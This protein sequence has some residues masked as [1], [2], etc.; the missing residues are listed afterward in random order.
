MP[1][2]CTALTAISWMLEPFG[3]VSTKSSI[4]LPSR[5]HFDTTYNKVIPE[6][7]CDKHKK[8]LVLVQPKKTRTCRDMAKIIDWDV[9]HHYRHSK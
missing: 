6:N 2:V 5:T 7:Q 1:Q 9:K 8:G 4:E 3:E